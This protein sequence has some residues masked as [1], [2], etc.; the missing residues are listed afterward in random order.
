MRFEQ[1]IARRFSREQNRGHEMS[2]PAIR[3]AIAGV[4]V[5]LA[6]MLI[7]LAVVIG[8]KREVTRQVVG[9]GSHITISAFDNYSNLL[10]TPITPTPALV[11][12]LRR[13]DNVTD[14]QFVARKPGI[15]QTDHAFQGVIIKGVDS[16]YNWDFFR[17]NLVRGELKNPDSIG[18]AAMISSTLARNMQLDTGQTFIV[19][20]VGNTLRARRFRVTAIYE[21][22]FSE[23]DNLYILT[24]IAQIRALNH[25]NDNQC[26]A[27]ELL[28]NDWSRVDHTC[29][30]VFRSTAREDEHYL[31]ET[32]RRSVPQIFDWLDM[33]DMNAVIILVLMML[34]SGFLVIS[35][36]LILILER[37]QTIGLMKA[38]G[39]TN[40]SLRIIFLTQAAYLIGRGLIVG[41]LIGL[42]L[43]ALQYF[44]GIIPLDPASYYV[45]HVPV[46]L[47]WQWW[48]GL[49]AGYGLLG[50][51]MLL[52]PSQLVSHIHPKELITND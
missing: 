12:R 27:L 30:R 2:R 40:R 20:F 6:V 4:A 34:V 21:T 16:T 9:F 1:F 52:L 7:S 51:L 10:D 42:G 23:Y 11:N 37:S 15:I 8:F 17:E 13:L 29:E 36:L 47:P 32:I 31:V 50:V 44:T 5:G 46:C 43:I 25:W 24:D 49:N 35:G 26:S 22:T 33:L 39:A 3:I 48:L 28:V 18:N 45:D 19:Y 14:V 41:N 38:M